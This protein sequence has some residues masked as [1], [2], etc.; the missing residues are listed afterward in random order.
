MYLKELKNHTLTEI[1]T[2]AQ[3]IR[4]LVLRVEIHLNYETIFF[5]SDFSNSH[6]GRKISRGGG[7][8][9]SM[10]KLIINVMTT[11]THKSK[12]NG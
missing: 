6:K 1:T 11:F 9:F 10:T 2:F 3:M 4:L 5:T 8:S 12:V 7:S